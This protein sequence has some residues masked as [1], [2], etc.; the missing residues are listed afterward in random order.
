MAKHVD[1]DRRRNEV[2]A[3]PLPPAATPSQEQSVSGPRE[4]IEQAAR[5]VKRGLVDTERRGIP[6]DV[7]GPRDRSTQGADVPVGGGNRG[8]FSERR[9]APRIDSAPPPGDQKPTRRG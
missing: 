3:A 7:P 5:D 9:R 1:T 2:K 8:S 6:T 4:V